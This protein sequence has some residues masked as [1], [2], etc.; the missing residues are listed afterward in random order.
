MS[1]Q[2]SFSINAAAKLTGFTIPTIRKRLPELEKQGAQLLGT[3]WNIPLSAL[4][5]VGLMSKVESKADSKV[6]QQALQGE[7]INEF[8][9]L[10]SQLADALQR[11]AVAEALAI[12]RAQSL[13]RVDRAM[14][15]LTAGTPV[16]KPRRGWF[17]RR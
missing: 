3:R 1:S 4:F 15:M 6:S 10:R 13:E 12:E 2:E 9:S 7:T 14:L 5:A 17:T 11:A 8:T 16:S